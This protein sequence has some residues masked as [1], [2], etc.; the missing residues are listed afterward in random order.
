MLET[1]SG[2]VKSSPFAKGRQ[3]QGTTALRAAQFVTARR[4]VVPCMQVHVSTCR[5]CSPPCIALKSEQGVGGRANR[6]RKCVGFAAVCAAS[7]AVVAMSLVGAAADD[8]GDAD[9]KPDVSPRPGQIIVSDG[10]PTRIIAEDG[11]TRQIIVN[12]GVQK[13]IIVEYMEPIRIVASDEN[14][15]RHGHR[16]SV[17]V[18]HGS[19]ADFEGEQTLQLADDLWLV[20]DEAQSR[21]IIAEGQSRLAAH[22]GSGKLPTV[23]TIEGMT[24][25]EYMDFVS[26]SME[27]NPINPEDDEQVCHCR[28]AAADS[29]SGEEITS[30]TVGSNDAFCTCETVYDTTNECVHASVAR[31]SEP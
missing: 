26:R 30:W 6:M 12:D 10:E 7:T 15:T 5:F 4:A 11:D 17:E 23:A 3:N 19:L 8:A 16:A 20:L 25:R 27:P 14:T 18:A 22:W 21:L 13:Q 24:S 29:C 28:V 1:H 31:L 9:G 2:S